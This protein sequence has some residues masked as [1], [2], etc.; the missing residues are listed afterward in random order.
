M[1]DWTPSW[2][3]Y[4][5]ITESLRM[6][7]QIILKSWEIG[8]VFGSVFGSVL[9]VS[10]EVFLLCNLKQQR[11]LNKYVLLH[12]KLS[13][14]LRQMK[15]KFFVISKI[16]LL[17]F[18]RCLR[19]FSDHRLTLLYPTVPSFLICSSCNIRRGF[20][21]LTGWEILEAFRDSG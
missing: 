13:F 2:V 8:S 3:V 21:V 6:T 1:L 4:L 5:G 20:I 19:T 12:D 10:L 9:E 18:S 15:I 11:L 7:Y 17:T 14:I 16:N